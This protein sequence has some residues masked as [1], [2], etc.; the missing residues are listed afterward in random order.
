MKG[1]M[2][3]SSYEERAQI[4]EGKVLRLEKELAEVK[5]CAYKYLAWLDVKNPRKGLEIDL[6][7]PDMLVPYGKW[8]KV[9]N[10]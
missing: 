10:K 3:A 2:L 4:A 1:L 8:S 5:E 7:D 6:K 9:R